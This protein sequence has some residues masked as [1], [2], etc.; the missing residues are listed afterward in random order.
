MDQKGNQTM[1]GEE[2]GILDLAVGVETRRQ[3]LLNR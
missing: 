1:Q 2:E 3:R